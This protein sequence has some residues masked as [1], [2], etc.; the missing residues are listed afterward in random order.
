VLDLPLAAGAVRR[1]TSEP[2][3]RSLEV[4][5]V[6]VELLHPPGLGPWPAW[7]FVNGAHP[8]RRREPV[9]ARLAEGLARAGHLVILPDL[10]GLGDG[11]ITT[12]T[13]DAAG[14]VAAAAV[15]L[16]EAR[17][18]RVALIGAS[19]GA[20]LALLVAARPALADR[21]SCVAAVAPFADI[22][23]LVCLATTGCYVEGDAFARYEVTELHRRV[24]AGSLVSLLP[25]GEDRERLLA[26]L[27][28][29]ANGSDPVARLASVGGVGADAQAVVRL[30]VNADPDRFRDLYAELPR[31]VRSRLARLSP[32]AGSGAVR[33]PV[34]VVVPP[35]DLYFPLGEA[36]AVAA[37]LPCARLTITKSLD[38][39]RPQA[40]FARLA[41]LRRFDG[42]VV[43]G[44]AS[45]AS[46]AVSK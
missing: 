35:A 41:D 18:G 23:K 3:V 8:E 14:A 33:A 27:D 20:G 2:E 17:R 43:R 34:E 11:R 12:R 19:T 21:I 24:V 26:E 16:P 29:S 40:S 42:F 7:L 13:V 46:E 1:L 22:E 6:P 28:R 4:D 30:L 32:L 37:A 25:P 15:R 44:L 31:S 38:H 45:A 36:V 9:V 39:T 5:G 10:P